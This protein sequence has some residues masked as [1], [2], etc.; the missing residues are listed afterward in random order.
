[1]DEHTFWW[2]VWGMVILFG[3]G[4]AVVPVLTLLERRRQ[5]REKDQRDD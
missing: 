1:M 5:R 4:V 3:V 2:F